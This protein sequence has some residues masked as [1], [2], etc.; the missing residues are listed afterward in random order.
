L[1]H[2]VLQGST[3]GKD[4]TEL[5]KRDTS[6]LN[7]TYVTKTYGVQPQKSGR[8]PQFWPYIR[9]QQAGA[10]SSGAYYLLLGSIEFFGCFW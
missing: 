5:D 8:D 4:W 1:L 7:G 10:N 6:D 2:W 9:L 3:N